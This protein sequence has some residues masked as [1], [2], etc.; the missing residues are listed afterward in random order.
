M[1][2]VPLEHEEQA[3]F[4][5]EV[6][7]R[8]RNNPTFIEELFFSVPNGIFVGGG[9]RGG[10]SATIAK[11]KA[12]GFNLGVADILYLQPRGLH[13][14][15][16]IEMKRQGRQNRKDGEMR[17]DQ[18]LFRDAALKVGAYHIIAYGA[19]EAILQFATYMLLPAVTPIFISSSSI[20]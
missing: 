19:D 11:Q 12:E 3:S 8:F 13:P 4:V 10:R 18:I 16:A 14:Y 2:I 5:T 6:K 1:K 17:P 7:Y 20:K 15:M 9:S